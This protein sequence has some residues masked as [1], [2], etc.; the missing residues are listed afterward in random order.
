MVTF[1]QNV[2]GTVPYSFDCSKTNR[3]VC[4]LMHIITNETLYELDMEAKSILNLSI[5]ESKF[6]HLPTNLMKIMPYLLQLIVK[7]CSLEYI[8]PKLFGTTDGGLFI[9]NLQTLILSDNQ[10]T[11]IDN[12][13]FSRCNNLEYLYIENNLISSIMKEAFSRL[14]SLSSL[15]LAYNRLTTLDEHVFVP[16]QKAINLNLSFNQLSDPASV[17]H[18]KQLQTLDLSF[19]K[20]IDISG[21]SVQGLGDELT[22][23]SLN[24]I[25]TKHSDDFLNHLSQ[26]NQLIS[27]YIN[28]NF[29]NHLNFERFEN[30]SNL[31][32]LSVFGNNLTEIPYTQ[33][34]NKFP[35]LRG[36]EIGDNPW[37]CSY[38]ELMIVKFNA[39]G[40]S[41]KSI[42]S[43]QNGRK[44]EGIGCFTFEE[45]KKKFANEKSSSIMDYWH[46]IVISSLMMIVLIFVAVSVKRK[47]Y[48][49][50]SFADDD[51]SYSS[52]INMNS[53]AYQA[54]TYNRGSIQLNPIYESTRKDSDYV[55]EVIYAEP[56]MIFNDGDDDD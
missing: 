49:H 28:E 15:N 8:N 33:M 7:N 27:M 41:L 35:G 34:K 31:K 26:F 17:C 36:I 55:D 13:S 23:L 30:F 22:S 40:I 46:F 56:N 4:S 51:L 47:F 3:Q 32:Q 14:F 37:E 12:F 18:L 43:N 39:L 53:I 21:L 42:I 52:S 19:N 11:R 9:P 25:S 20:K 16:L 44:K 45:L 10:L 48:N 24:G 6:S 1:L 2:W 29:I 5:L 54:D 50:P 38:L